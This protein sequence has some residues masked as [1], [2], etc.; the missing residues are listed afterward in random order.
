MTPAV[1]EMKIRKQ[2][3]RRM[4]GKTNISV[5]FGVAAHDRATTGTRGVCP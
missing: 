2:T 1:A 3:V 4:S 5:Q